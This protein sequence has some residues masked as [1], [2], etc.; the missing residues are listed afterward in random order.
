MNKTV[1]RWLA[2]LLSLVLLLSLCACGSDSG[3][4]ST[5]GDVEGPYSDVEREPR[6]LHW[7]SGSS[8]GQGYITGSVMAG[9]LP[10]VYGGYSVIP[11]VTTGG[12]D[13]GK[14]LLAG[15]GDFISMQSDDAVA[16]NTNER[17]WVGMPECTDRLRLVCVFS[18]TWLHMITRANNDSIN[19]FSDLK[20][21]RVGVTAGSTRSYM[22]QFLLQSHDMTEDDFSSLNDMSYPDL[23]TS[24]QNDTIDAMIDM[25]ALG[26]SG[27]Q[28]LAYSVKGI[29]FISLDDKE[30]AAMQAI[31]GAYQKGK[32]PADI[33][34]GA[35]EGQT[36]NL[37]NLY[38]TE[39]EMPDYVVYDVVKCMYENDEDLKAA[40]PAAGIFIDEDVFNNHLSLIPLHPGAKTFYEELGW[41]D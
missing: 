9:L 24:L 29:K 23:V 10:E 34:E 40:H 3:N 16:F 39:K 19:S 22:L 33:Y 35:P 26:H 25:R 15:T 12:V 31:N 13:N 27:Y 11:E 5:S 8:S 2:A 28:E 17:D 37:Y 7:A 6:A 21:K 18:E 32:V 20:G 14:M 30:V 1:S 38:L 41:V 36:I 4:S